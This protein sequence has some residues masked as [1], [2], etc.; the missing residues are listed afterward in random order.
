MKLNIKRTMLAG[1]A[2]MAISGFWA[3]YNSVTPLILEKTFSLSA[4][5]NGVVMAMD[6]VLAVFLLPIFGVWSDRTHTR[7]GKRMPFII[8]GTILSI[9]AMVLMP[10]A[11]NTRNFVLFMTATGAVLLFMSFYRSPAV[12]LMPDITPRQLRSKGNAVIMLMGTVGVIYSMIITKILVT[13]DPA[14]KPDYL[15]LFIAMIVMMGISLVLM[16]IFVD[17][18]KWVKDARKN[19]I[20]DEDEDKAEVAKGRKLSKDKLKSLIFLLLSV[21]FWYMAYNGVET[22]ISRYTMA[23]WG[24]GPTGYTTY[25]LIATVSAVLCYIP[26]GILSGKFG[27]KKIILF[28]VIGLSV[29]FFLCIFFKGGGLLLMLVFALIGISWGSI[30]VNSFPM[31]VEIAADG[32]EGKYTGLYYMF[33]MVAQVLTPILSGFLIDKTTSYKVLF[34]YA[35]IFSVLAIITMTQVNHGDIVREKDKKK[36]ILEHLDVDA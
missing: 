3:M 21:A 20:P 26:I 28:G 23:E 27:R 24:M 22:A 34:P 14:V 19:D 5:W 36:S 32:D 33:S 12:A 13:S 4:T 9:L 11:D 15:P 18:N 30:N 17:E 25:M 6:N 7:L 29:A 1:L 31:V 8:A 16:E 35:T 2:F 10:I